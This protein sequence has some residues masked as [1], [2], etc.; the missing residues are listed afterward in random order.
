MVARNKR[1]PQYQLDLAELAGKPDLPR[2]RRADEEGAPL[3]IHDTT[4]YDENQG[5]LGQNLIDLA[6][7]K[8]YD[9]DSFFEYDGLTIETPVRMIKLPNLDELLEH[10]VD[11]GLVDGDEVFDAEIQ[12]IIELDI[13][14]MFEDDSDLEHTF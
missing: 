5:R 10:L 14:A 4:L 12:A 2:A 6:T 7:G 3:G 11:E 1:Y 9:N 13:A 8:P